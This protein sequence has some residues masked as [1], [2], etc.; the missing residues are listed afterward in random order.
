MRLVDNDDG[1]GREH[2]GGSMTDAYSRVNAASSVGGVRY[3]VDM[4][5]NTTEVSNVYDWC[6]SRTNI[7]IDDDALSIVMRRYGLRT[8]TEAVDLALRSLAGRPMTIEEALEM[9]GYGGIAEIPEDE[10]IS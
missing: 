3:L 9:R 5:R 4:S 1:G 2:V 8:K 6:M 7:E 10:P